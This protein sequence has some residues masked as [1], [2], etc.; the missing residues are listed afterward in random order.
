MG[1]R[2]A[3]SFN[4]NLELG[5]WRMRRILVTC[6]HSG[7]DSLNLEV[8]GETLFPTHRTLFMVFSILVFYVKGFSIDTQMR[9]TYLIVMMIR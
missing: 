2:F 5:L 8:I 7:S 3:V 4:T 9:C 1:T 6:G